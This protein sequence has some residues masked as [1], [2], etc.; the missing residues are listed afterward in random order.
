MYGGSHD[1]FGGLGVV[2]STTGR[3]VAVVVVDG[4][5]ALDAVVLGAG[6]LDPALGIEP[7]VVDGAAVTEGWGGVV[8]ATDWDGWGVGSFAIVRRA[9][10]TTSRITPRSAISASAT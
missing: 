1:G 9:T 2:G 6:A 10:P 4:T 8:G 7:V 5:P 3:A